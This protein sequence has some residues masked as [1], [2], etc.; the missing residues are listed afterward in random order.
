ME[1]KLN[2][3]PTDETFSNAIKS[4]DKEIKD[5]IVQLNKEKSDAKRYLS[6]FHYD[7]EFFLFFYV[8]KFN[9]NYFV[10]VISWRS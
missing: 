3:K 7:V 6:E 4:L 5:I 8:Q 10:D 2:E 9:F 1:V